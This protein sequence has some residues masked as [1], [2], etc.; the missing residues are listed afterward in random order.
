MWHAQ[1]RRK[2][3]L[4]VRHR[5]NGNSKETH[6]SLSKREEEPEGLFGE[7]PLILSDIVPERYILM[8][9]HY[10]YRSYTQFGHGRAK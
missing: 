8:G 2:L 1:T 9:K 10:S 7:G 5:L 4:F 3:F 6:Y